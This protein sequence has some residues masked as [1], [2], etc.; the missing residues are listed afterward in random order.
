VSEMERRF[1]AVIVAL[2][3]GEVVSYGDVAE[4][5]GFPG[6]SRAVGSLLSNT[7]LDLPWWRVVRSDGRLATPPTAGQAALLRAEGVIV[8]GGR[9]IESPAGRFRR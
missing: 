7:P 1:V 5:A 4:D 2:G 8:R 6:R 9:V 3:E